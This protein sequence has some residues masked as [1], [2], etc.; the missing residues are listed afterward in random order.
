MGIS[1]YSKSAFIVAL[2]GGLAALIPFTAS[3]LHSLHNAKAAMQQEMYFHIPNIEDFEEVKFLP[4]AESVK[5]I[6]LGYQNVLAQLL[7]FYTQNYFGKHYRS[8]QRYTWLYYM[9]DLITTLDPNHKEVFNF[10]TMML[11]WEAKKPQ[12]ALKF[13]S[14]GLVHHP[15]DWYFYY[16]RGSLSYLIENNPEKA[17]ED[18]RIGASLPDAPAMMS[19]IAAKKMV[20]INQDPEGAVSFLQEMIH[21]TKNPQ[22]IK[23]LNNKIM[24]IRKTNT[25]EETE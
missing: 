24:E 7:W 15:S 8:D 13:I 9:C 4:K 1:F 21:S 17:I 3:S 20:S 18:F 19:S 25:S 14:K 2:V 12:E 6:S 22:T 11:G 10:G 5:S 23:I 16:L